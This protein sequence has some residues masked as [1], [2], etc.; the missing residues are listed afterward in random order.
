MACFVV[1]EWSRSSG[2]RKWQKLILSVTMYIASFCLSHLAW[3]PESLGKCLFL[4]AVLPMACF[5]IMI[6]GCD[7]RVVE[8][9]GLEFTRVLWILA[10]A[11]SGQ[12]DLGWSMTGSVWP[13][14]TCEFVP[15]WSL[16]D[17]SP[18]ILT[19]HLQGRR[20]AP[21]T[22]LRLFIR[23]CRNFHIPVHLHAAPRVQ[24]I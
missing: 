19:G 20:L 3:V 22:F 7:L 2:K 4:E 5:C 16:V 8:R 6:S 9:R 23:A 14:R 21:R 10:G 1:F 17:R 11:C 13:F 15:E 12:A 24:G 18:F